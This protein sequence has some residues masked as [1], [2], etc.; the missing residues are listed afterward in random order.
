MML[1][2]RMSL[3]VGLM[4][5]VVQG[6]LGLACG[7]NQG[8][9]TTPQGNVAKNS[10]QDNTAQSNTTPAPTPASARE[11]TVSDALKVL[12]EGGYGKV[13][14]AFVA[15]VR[16][17]ET[18]AALR[19]LAGDA[20]ELRADFFKTNIVVAAFLGTRN[21]GGFGVQITRGATGA[22]VRVA[23]TTPPKGAMTTQALTAPFKF[24][25]MAANAQEA[26]QLELDTAWTRAGR[27]Y[28]LR[29]GEFT[30]SGG[31]AGRAEQFRLEGDLR[32]L[33]L[34]KL[35]TVVF[36]LH[37]TG[38]GTRPRTLQ[39]AATGLVESQVGF[40]LPRLVSGSLVGWPNGGLR[41]SGQLTGDESKLTLAFEPLPA[42]A[43]DSFQGQGK[44]SADA[45]GPAPPKKPA[46][47]PDEM[48]M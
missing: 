36:D 33:R 14:D 41:A 43:S 16:D 37:G 8:R 22:T 48:P 21:T 4:L 31:L 2:M 20:P 23:E 38:A 1:G 30:S 27:P 40:R 7:A 12:A 13:T 29:D 47:R 15:V 32:V 35:V 42:N 18:Y 45:T 34:D 5:S 9:Q 24:V 19:E 11:G 10:P 6:A 26:L 17:A 3:A 25:S 39:T 28:R 44:L 46:T